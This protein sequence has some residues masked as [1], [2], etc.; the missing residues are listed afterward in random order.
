VRTL[1]VVYNGDNVLE[2]L[3]NLVWLAVAISLWGL[4]F[5][6]RRGVGK[7][8]L[9]HS[10]GTEV[11]A[12]AM[13]TTILLPAISITDDLHACQLPA[14]IKR[15]VL[16]SDR[17]L[18]PAARPRVQPFP[19]ALLALFCMSPLDYG[20]MTFVAVEQ[21]TR[22]FMRGYLR[23]LWSRPPPAQTA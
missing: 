15:S 14:E 6:R 13:L 9:F 10:V 22:S 12:L 17:H 3:S 21:P 18:S 19:L 2:L 20:G 23:S 16:Q 7:R 4:W 8:S 1:A 5:L 11:I